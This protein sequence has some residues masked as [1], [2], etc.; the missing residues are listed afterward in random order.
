[1]RVAALAGRLGCRA[2]HHQLEGA[3]SNRRLTDDPALKAK[4]GHFVT[5]RLESAAAI[6]QAQAEAAR[7]FQSNFQDE[8]GALLTRFQLLALPSVKFC[9]TARH[10]SSAVSHRSAPRLLFELDRDAQA[11]WRD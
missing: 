5:E 9:A 11:A 3:R 2:G 10:R 1:M 6:T 4:L 7:R 8:L